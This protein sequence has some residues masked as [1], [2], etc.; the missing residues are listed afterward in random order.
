MALRVYV[1]TVVADA[2]SV[3]ARAVT[4]AIEAEAPR[5]REPVVVWTG[6]EDRPGHTPA[7][8]TADGVF[9]A[10]GAAARLSTAGRS[11]RAGDHPCADEGPTVELSLPGSLAPLH[12]RES[13]IVARACLVA[14]C[15]ESA[16]GT[17]PVAS[18]F[19]ALAHRL[20]GVRRSDPAAHTSRLGARWAPLLFSHVGVVID[21]TW[22]ARAGDDDLVAVERCVG[23]SSTDAQDVDRVD[24]WLA[25][26]VGRT[27]TIGDVTVRGR[28]ASAPWPTIRAP[29]QDTPWAQ[30]TAGGLWRSPSPVASH[31]GSRPQP[32][33][34][35]RAWDEYGR[36]G[37]R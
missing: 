30:R 7:G 3:A 36:E 6:G 33:S 35:A 14:P 27:A 11:A 21:A 19:A 15:L 34:L 32:G 1:E 4:D 31:R 17:G 23:F 8:W 26:Q 2:P 16:D 9:E 20:G 18:A 13:W 5:G 25:A 29:E 37:R 10:L 22:W 12:V 24:R 28:G